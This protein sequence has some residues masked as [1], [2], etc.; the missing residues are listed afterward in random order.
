MIYNDGYGYDLVESPSL[1]NP[2][3]GEIIEINNENGR[4]KYK[5]RFD[6]GTIKNVSEGIFDDYIYKYAN[7]GGISGLDDLLRG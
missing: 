5:I 6:N 1:G 2:E 4:I 7:G 3:D